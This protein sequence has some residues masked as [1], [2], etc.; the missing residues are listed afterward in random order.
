MTR[1]VSIEIS[2][3]ILMPNA[4]TGNRASLQRRLARFAAVDGRR[5]TRLLPLFLLLL[6]TVARTRAQ[7]PLEGSQYRACQG[8]PMCAAV[9][10][11]D[12]I[13]AE[14]NASPT[15][16]EAVEGCTYLD[17]K[18][19]DVPNGG[20]SSFLSS[21]GRVAACFGSGACGQV[22]A[23][24]T[25]DACEAANDGA[26][27]FRPPEAFTQECVDNGGFTEASVTKD[28][29]SALVYTANSRG[30]TIP[31]FSVVGYKG[32]LEPLPD[33]A[34]VPAAGATLTPSA[35][36][37]DTEAI[38]AEI[39]RVSLLPL[40]ANGYR[41][42]VELS[43]GR[44][45]TTGP[46]FLEV[47]ASARV[48]AGTLRRTGRRWIGVCQARTASGSDGTASGIAMGLLLRVAWSGN[49]SGAPG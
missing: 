38:Q 43:A 14:G 9:E 3:V 12:L 28:A 1:T 16:C 45:T 27:T 23:L 33:G 32:D 19:P 24:D 17:C 29:T 35:S 7:G 40:G 4:K 11:A 2:D 31:D 15:A 8:G 25:P 26:C 13:D 41:G 34:S 42:A 18:D 49:M 20:P 48:V 22:T 21:P 44:F 47:F 36:G 10:A 6:F 30:D 39:D 5:M 46:L 37:D